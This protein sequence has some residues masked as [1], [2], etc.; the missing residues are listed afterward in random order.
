MALRTRVSFALLVGAHAIPLHPPAED[1][2][3]ASSQSHQ[4]HLHHAKS[5]S[6]LTAALSSSASPPPPPAPSPPPCGWDPAPSATVVPATLFD[7]SLFK[8]QTDLPKCSGAS[9]VRQFKGTDPHTD[10]LASFSSSKFFATSSPER[11]I[12]FITDVGGVTTKGSDGRTGYPRTELREVTSTGADAAWSVQGRHSL[13]VR[14][15]VHKLPVGKESVIIAQVKSNIIK[16]VFLKMRATV[17]G[18]TAPK[19][20]IEARVKYNKP[21]GSVGEMGLTFDRQF[22]LGEKFDINIVVTGLQVAVT[23]NAVGEA[24]Q[25]LTHDYST[26]TPFS[27]TLTGDLYYFKAG[28]YCQS[29]LKYSAAG[30]QCEVQLHSVALAHS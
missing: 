16:D 3:L 15:S 8:L 10:N 4:H 1:L 24:P 13:T 28:S 30:Q 14:E 6:N 9:G 19:F 29:N 12:T 5:T 25:T 23:V 27:S 20:V 2:K 22:A 21:S 17:R 11:A 7:L 26:F 18:S